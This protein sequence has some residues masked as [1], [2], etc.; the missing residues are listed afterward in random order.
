MTKRILAD[1]CI[2]IEYFRTTSP[3]S[4]EL[5]KLIREDNIV[6]T[7]LVILE[8][9]QGIK[10]PESKELIKDTIL[11]L[12]FLE[13]TRDSWIIAGEIG[14]TLRRKGL[15]LPATD[16]LLAA[17]A[18]INDCSIFTTDA[19]FKVIPDIDLYPLP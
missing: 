8:L 15:T 17:V 12:P 5:R 10:T 13:A 18:K 1:T 9:F 7:G 19:H 2:W 6:T 4:D 11:A 3:I 14:Y 16:L